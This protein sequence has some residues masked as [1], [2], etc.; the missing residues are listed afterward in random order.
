MFARQDQRR[1]PKRFRLSTSRFVNFRNAADR[2]PDATKRKAKAFSRTR[3]RPISPLSELQSGETLMAKLISVLTIAVVIG[4]AI[5][6]AA[7]TFVAL[8]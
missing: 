3:G 5:A 2:F 1:E 7:Y 4:A 8:A 6:P